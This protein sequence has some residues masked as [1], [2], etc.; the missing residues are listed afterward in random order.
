MK[1]KIIH[2]ILLTVLLTAGRILYKSGD[3]THF[4]SDP[5]LFAMAVDDYS[6]EDYRPHL[7]G[8]FL[9][10]QLA[11]VVIYFGC[12]PSGALIY[13]SILYSILGAIVFYMFAAGH[14]GNTSAFYLTILMSFNPFIWF[15]SCISEIYIVELLLSL[16]LVSLGNS[17]KGL[18]YTPLL[19]A[20][21]MWHPPEYFCTFDAAL[22]V[23][24]GQEWQRHW[25]PED[26]P[27]PYCR[28]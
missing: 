10:V 13:L 8:Y 21:G 17:R 18:L 12:S 27:I 16:L 4:S 20:L 22:F 1:T 26:N 6:L 23:S 28:G 3:Y 14:I 5:P 25:Y 19:A 24:L 15:F 9:H 7:P 11:K 2:L